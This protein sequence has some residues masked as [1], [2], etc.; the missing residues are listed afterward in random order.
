MLEIKKEQL[1]GLP[2][3]AYSGRV[4]VVDSASGCRSAMRYLKKQRV[5]GFDTET[6][7]SFRKGHTHSVA[8]LQLST[9]GECFLIRLNKV[10]L[11]DET[12]RFFED[13]EIVKVGLSVKDDIHSLLK[14][15]QFE[16]RN[17]VE[18]QSYVKDFSISDNS[19]QKVYGIIFGRRI[20]KSQRLSNWEADQLT[21][22]QQAYAALDAYACIEIYNYLKS[23]NFDPSLSPYQLT[24]AE[25]PQPAC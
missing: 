11:T 9:M 4:V 22:A 6:R 20:S 7:P 3:A 14:L 12:V 15:R 23:G 13:E 17:V 8:L 16:P 21:E 24:V 18:L 25:E 2:V 19:L 1:A 10:G 5:V